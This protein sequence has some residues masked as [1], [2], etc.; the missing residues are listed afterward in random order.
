MVVTTT[1]ASSNSRR[2]AASAATASTAA[3][4]A[5]A[6]TSTSATTTTA[7]TT[8]TGSRTTRTA[9][10]NPPA[11]NVTVAG[12]GL[13]VFI[14]QIKE[15]PVADILKRFKFDHLTPIEGEPNYRA[16]VLAR[17]ELS[18]NAMAIKISLCGGRRGCLSLV[19]PPATYFQVA[20]TSA[21]TPLSQGPYPTFPPGATEQ[22][23][24]QLIAEFI[25]TEQDL[26]KLEN[27]EELLKNQFLECI[28]E[29]FIRELHDPVSEYDD[30]TLL[31][32]L[33]HVFAN[34]GQMD[35]HLVNANK[36]RFDEPPDMDSPLDKYFVKQEEC[37]TLSNDSETPITD[38]DMAQKLTTHMGKTN[39]VD[40]QN[41][42]FKNL[43]PGDRTWA[44]GKAYFRSVLTMLKDIAKS[45][46]EDGLYANSAMRHAAP[47]QVEQKVREEIASKLGESFESLACA[48]TIKSDVMDNHSRIIAALT[49]T[50]AE[51]VATNKLLVTQLAGCQGR[52]TGGTPAPPTPKWGDAGPT[53]IASALTT[54][55]VDAAVNYN[56][57]TQKHYFNNKQACAYCKRDAITHIPA[58]CLYNPANKAQLDARNARDTARKAAGKV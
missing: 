6:S 4:A 26:L 54:G 3:A 32:L 14:P 25:T 44:K 45:A 29:D 5:T 20:G 7:G 22:E 42:R 12:A 9:T 30:I 31:E 57:D 55:G 38:A 27:T 23:K 8:V 52:N 28:D 50:N 41:Y 40:K 36:E 51:L 49:K 39:M 37:Q 48:A 1:R 24:K 46:G 33:D 35:D 21:V 47:A 13:D 2:A 17:R 53:R 34:Y 18:R 56:P 11:V 58:N 10:T 19:L 15:T 43:P 16:L